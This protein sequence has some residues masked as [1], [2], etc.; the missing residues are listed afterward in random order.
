MKTFTALVVWLMVPKV[1]GVETHVRCVPGWGMRIASLHTYPV[2]GGHRLDHDE[3]AVERWGLAGD[4][5]WMVIDPDGVGI[6]QR[7]VTRLA[8]LTVTPRPGGLTLRAP[9]QP[10]LDVAFPA[11]GAIEHVRVF[12]SK[13]PA[14]ARLAPA[15][16]GDWLTGFLGQPARLAW[17]GDPATARPVQNNAEVGDRV[18][19]ADGYPLLVANTASLDMVNDWL[20]EAGD[21][22]VPM[23]RF[24]PNVVVSGAAPWAEDCWLGRRVRLGDVVLRAVKPCDRCL[25][26]TIDQETGVRGKQPLRILGQ[27]RRFPG[28]LMFGMNLIPD[29]PGLMRVGDEVLDLP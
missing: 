12:S 9:E 29:H 23:T 5:R 4:R 1:H 8:L 2:K 26:T 15:G 14:P 21:E 22:T 17:L 19:F 24:R 10:D 6:T 13:P 3:A 20:A 7:D 18:S 25:V 28:G 27:Y 16:A 11:G